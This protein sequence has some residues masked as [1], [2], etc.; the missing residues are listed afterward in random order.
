VLTTHSDTDAEARHRADLA[1]HCRPTLTR[2]DRFYEQAERDGVTV[3]EFLFD[4]I[5]RKFES[6][7]DGDE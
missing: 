7:A 4:M 6:L 2:S 5:R 1:G 3:E